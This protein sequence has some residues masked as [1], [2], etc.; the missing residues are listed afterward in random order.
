MII[1]KCIKSRLLIEL[2]ILDMSNIDDEW[3]NSDYR[4][5]QYGKD[6]YNSLLLHNLHK[7]DY[8]KPSASAIKSWCVMA[9]ES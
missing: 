8:F 3:T 2:K 7:Y 4:S 6:F 9:V 1:V 5:V